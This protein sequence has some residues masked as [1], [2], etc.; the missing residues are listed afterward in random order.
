MAEEAYIASGVAPA[1]VTRGGKTG[2][3]VERIKR[4]LRG[5]ERLTGPRLRSTGVESPSFTLYM[6]KVR[7]LD[8]RFYY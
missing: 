7:P 5:R 2:T 6:D 8:M 4:L 3:L 1:G